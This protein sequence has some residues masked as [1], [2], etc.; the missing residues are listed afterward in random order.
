MGS[1]KGRGSGWG[2]GRGGVVRGV[3]EGEGQWVGSRKGRGST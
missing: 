1:R 2:Q 3:K